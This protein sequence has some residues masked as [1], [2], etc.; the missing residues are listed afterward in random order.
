[1][2]TSNWTLV[3][4]LLMMLSAA[5]VIWLVR[6]ARQSNRAFEDARRVAAEAQAQLQSSHHFYEAFCKHASVDVLYRR[7]AA[8]RRQ[9][10]AAELKQAGL[11]IDVNTYEALKR[12]EEA[13]R[14]LREAIAATALHEQTALTSWRRLMHLLKPTSRPAG[15]RSLHRATSA[16][17]FLGTL[18]PKRIANEEIGDALE[19]IHAMVKARRPR[20]FITIKVSTTFFWVAVHTGLHY[21]ERVAGI[22]GKATGGKGD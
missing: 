16:L 5:A 19:Q 9:S 1:M 11:L 3:A 12:N 20:W 14:L 6:R 8:K 22:I 17:D 15:A 13:L 18:V 21:A 10:L 7:A 2:S 4:L